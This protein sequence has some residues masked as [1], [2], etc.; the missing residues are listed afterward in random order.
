MKLACIL[1]A[2]GASSRFG[3]NKLLAE[4]HGKPLFQYAL[5]AIP[6]GLFDRILVVTGQGAIAEKARHMGFTPL[7]NNCPQE[8]VSRTIRLGLEG[9]GDCDGALFMTADQPLLSAETLTRLT[10]AFEREPDC[11]HAAAYNGRRG[12]PVLFPG[13]LFE[14]LCKLNGDVGGGKVIKAH[15]HLLR[16]TEV[17]EMELFDCDTKEA[18]EEFGGTDCHGLKALQ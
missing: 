4:L 7:W 11:I 6:A 2:A 1:M 15:P 18:L 13:F 14:E 10:R 12:N 16:L 17:P 5:E 3:G 8:G 9:A